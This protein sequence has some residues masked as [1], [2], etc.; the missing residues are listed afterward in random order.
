MNAAILASQTFGERLRRARLRAGL[1]QEALAER[2]RLSVSAIAALERGRRTVPRLSTI[3]LLADALGLPP[4]ERARLVSDAVERS[5]ENVGATPTGP[6]ASAFVLL[7]APLTPLFGRED[8]ISRVSEL[9]RPTA[10]H[11]RL[12]TLTGP[13]GV[14]KTRLAIAVAH[15]L[16]GDFADGVAFVD[17]TSLREER[18]VPA[19]VA[20]A[21]GLREQGGH[22]ALDLVLNHLRGRCMLL[23]LDNLEQVLPVGALLSSLVASCPELSLLVTSRVALNVRAEQRFAVA[24]LATPGAV[25]PNALNASEVIAQ[26]PAANWFINR[27]QAIDPTFTL[28]AANAHVVASIC[29]RLDGLPLAIELAAAHVGVLTVHTLLQRLEHALPLLARG[30]TDLPARQR[31]L[32][33]T[34]D[35]SYSLL[36]EPARATL[37]GLS[38]FRGGW[39]LEAAEAI[40]GTVFPQTQLLESLHELVDHSLVT[41]M[42]TADSAA[43]YSMLTTIRDYAQLQLAGRGVIDQLRLAHTRYFLEL[44]LSARDRTLAAQ[45]L[46]WVDRLEREHDNLQ[47]ALA[48]ADQLGDVETE[49]C[50][51]SGL[52]RF[53][54]LHCHLTLARHWLDA[55]LARPVPATST[56]IA[57]RA[58]ALAGRAA[59]A[60]VQTDYVRASAAA[61]EGVRL[62]EQ[63]GDRQ[64]VVFMLN[65]LG[66]VARNHSELAR[67]VELGAQAEALAR[68]LHDDWSIALVLHNLADVARIQADF[69]HAEQLANESLAISARSNNG[70]GILQ[71]QIVLGWIAFDT[72]Q[73]GRAGELF[74]LCRT[75]AAELGHTR[76]LARALAGL[77]EV[78][79]ARGELDEAEALLQE[80][81]VDWQTVGDAIRLAQVLNVRARLASLDGRVGESASCVLRA[82]ALFRSAEHH[83]GVAECLEALVGLVRAQPLDA[84]AATDVVELIAHAAHL[85]ERIGAPQTA[86][87]AGRHLDDL[88]S[89][90]AHLEQGELEQRWQSAPSSALDDLVR[91]LNARYDW[92]A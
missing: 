88:G 72:E 54:Y 62:A 89:A 71:S 53:W 4:E 69:P 25:D 52:W 34:L 81:E 38:V 84:A 7:P 33:T 59:V 16:R 60:V 39:T 43:R 37:C 19:S 63:I 51:V 20:R 30:S 92:T 87:E 32:E 47:E 78:A 44:A 26:A 75:M 8:D 70:W 31:T 49:L 85:R 29:R 50:L 2:A 65:C 1:T 45:Q 15:T 66:V 12:V 73:Y 40:V 10:A 27:A 11:K 41:T 14:G 24:P 13:G 48:Y 42:R 23:V 91:R 76:D 56:G 83:L 86:A 35:W 28:D 74:Q 55:A 68:E 61:E 22:S 64:N 46:E 80:A 36:S 79:L 9:L 57:A 21:L 77:G 5:P 58:D 17:L 3:G 82:L 90:R 6:V 67:A 18:L